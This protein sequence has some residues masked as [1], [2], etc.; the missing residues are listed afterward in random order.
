M[1]NRVVTI[2][3]VLT[4]NHLDG[5][6]EPISVLRISFGN[7]GLCKTLEGIKVGKNTVIEI[8]SS[9]STSSGRQ[10]AAR[11]VAQLNR[12]IT[13]ETVALELQGSIMITV[14]TDEDPL[15]IRVTVR[16]S[17]VTY[18]EARLIWNKEEVL[19]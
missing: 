5:V 18:Q 10:V 16:D 3:G 7:H 14:E 12:F 1:L 19:N 11:F 13:S 17:K 2:K 4:P 8:D 6:I 9:I 15:T